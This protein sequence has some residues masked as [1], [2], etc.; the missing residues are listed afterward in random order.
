MYY[1]SSLFDLYLATSAIPSAGLGVFTNTY[2]PSNTCID[3]YKGDIYKYRNASCYILEITDTHYIDGRDY[4]R[5]YMAMLNDCSHI[6]KQYIKKK[7]KRID[8]TPNAYYDAHNRTL[9][10]NCEFRIDETNKQAFIYSTAEIH[11]GS[12]LFVSY[13]DEYWRNR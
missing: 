6:T 3:E 12:E 1:H 10:I 11:P 5:C 9:T 4:P 7:K 13:G 2:I 8:V